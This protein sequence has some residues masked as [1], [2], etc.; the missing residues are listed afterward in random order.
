[1]GSMGIIGFLYGYIGVIWRH[2]GMMER[3]WKLVFTEKA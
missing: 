3:T 1:M 2:T